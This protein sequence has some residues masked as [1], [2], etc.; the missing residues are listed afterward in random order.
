VAF[1]TYVVDGTVNG[2]ARA[3]GGLATVGRRF[4]TGFVRSYALAVLTGAVLVTVLF[5]SSYLAT[6]G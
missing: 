4:Q 5:L 6:T 2:L 3:T 1:D